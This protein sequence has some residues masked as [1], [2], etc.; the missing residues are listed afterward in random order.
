MAKKLGYGQW[1]RGK[2]LSTIHKKNIAKALK[3]KYVGEKSSAWRRKHSEKWYKKMKGHSP[4]NKGKVGVMPPPWNKGKRTGIAPWRGKKRENLSGEKHF[5][6][7]G[8]ITPINEKIR[9]TPEYRRWR[10][11]VFERDNYICQ[12]CLR[13]GGTLHA[14]HIKPFAFFEEIR[15]D[16]ENGRTLCSLCH[17]MTETWGTGAKK[18]KDKNYDK[19]VAA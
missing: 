13:R 3:G 10:I 14:D 5:N 11:S 15:L 7:Q 1:M 12:I 17:R 9:K 18:F 2:K 4:W 19:T 6:W 16:V 8:G